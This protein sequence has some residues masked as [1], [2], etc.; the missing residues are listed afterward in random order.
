MGP[1]Y[2]KLLKG[3]IIQNITQT[4]ELFEAAEENYRA[5]VAVESFVFRYTMAPN[6]CP[7]YSNS[8]KYTIYA[9]NNREFGYGLLPRFFFQE[10]HR[11]KKMLLD[12]HP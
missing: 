6:E 12:S 9:H 4:L 10:G 1:Q 2:C 3:Y 7:Q 8:S 5:D 11:R